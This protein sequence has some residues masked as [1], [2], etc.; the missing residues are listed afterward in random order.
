MKTIKKWLLRKVFSAIMTKEIAIRTLQ[1]RC[2]IGSIEWKYYQSKINVLN[3]LI[4]DI[5]EL[6]NL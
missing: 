1:E 3:D 5:K 4:D 6:Y 2:V